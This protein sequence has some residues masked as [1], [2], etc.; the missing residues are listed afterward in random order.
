MCTVQCRIYD[1]EVMALFTWF[2]IFAWFSIQFARFPPVPAGHK[3]AEDLKKV[4]IL[5][6]RIAII[7]Y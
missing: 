5:L 6:G 2:G 4:K 7:N 3:A 1:A